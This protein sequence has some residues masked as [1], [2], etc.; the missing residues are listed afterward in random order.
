[1]I[2][3][4]GS[5]IVDHKTNEKILQL[6]ESGRFQN[7]I[8]SENEL[9]FY[10]A[11]PS[12]NYI[13]GRFAAKEA[14][15]KALGTGMH[16]GISLKEIDISTLETGQPYVSLSGYVKSLAE[17]LNITKWHLTVSHSEGCTLAFAISE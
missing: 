3:G 7:R 5:D 12:Q 16:D 17:Q 1:M 8:L 2:I 9:S 14:I 11:S 13:V 6:D 4:I 15:L 10:K